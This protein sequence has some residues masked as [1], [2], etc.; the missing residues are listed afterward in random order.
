MKIGAHVLKRRPL[1]LLLLCFAV[2]AFAFTQ[3][4]LAVNT[5][6]AVYG[7]VKNSDNST[8]GDSD[9]T[10]KAYITDRPTEQLTQASTGCGYASGFYQVE[11]GNFTSQWKAGETLAVEFVNSKNN[12]KKTINVVLDGAAAQQ[13]EGVILQPKVLQSIAIAAPANT[14]PVGEGLQF[15]ATG[16]YDDSSTEDITASATWTVTTVDPAGA[17][18]FDAAVKGRL[19]ALKQGNA[20]VKAAKD[21]KDSPTSNVTVAAFNGTVT[22]TANP[23]SIVAN[24]TSTSAISAAV[25]TNGGA[26]VVDGVTVAFAKTA[27]EGAVAPA[28][29]T[30]VNGVASTTYTSGLSL[31]HI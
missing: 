29:A 31:I 13:S 15:T 26:N 9:V 25:K 6:K 27:G 2:G 8:P 4:I 14:V 30:T 22:V 1:L 17:A 24:G 5:P 19:N 12:E 7:T 20:V 18:A 3:I 16:T 23:T 21:G 28:T 11:V 10:F